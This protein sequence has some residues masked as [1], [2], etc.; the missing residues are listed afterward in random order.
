MKPKSIQLY[1]AGNRLFLAET[2]SAALK[3]AIHQP[4]VAQVVTVSDPE[5]L[6]MI[7][8]FE[9]DIEVPF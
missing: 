7:Q 6:A 1:F 4:A 9:R 2:D 5:I 3:V 8:R